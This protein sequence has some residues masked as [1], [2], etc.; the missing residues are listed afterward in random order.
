MANLPFYIVDVFAEARYAGNPLAVVRHAAGL[1]TEEMQA[2]AREMHY[3][4]TT[5]ILDDG[6][7]DG[8]YNVRIFTMDT[9]LAFAGHPTLGTAYVI[10]HEIAPTTAATE[11]LILNL[12]V[13]PIPVTFAGDG[14]LWMQQN[15]PEFDHIYDTAAIAEVLNL[16][17]DDLDPAHPVQIVSTGLPFTIVP[18]RTLNALKRVQVDWRR[19]SQMTVGGDEDL[20]GLL[21]FAPETYHP[22]NNLNVRVLFETDT[23]PEDPA[24][25]SANGCLAAYL[26]HRRYLGTADIACRVE[27]GYEIGRPSL[28]HL[29]A[30]AHGAK[31]S[32][33]VGGKVQMVARGELIR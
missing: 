3:S 30:K 32:V 27:Q 25:G 10:R 16:D 29:R 28:L 22:E 14:L 9:E 15:P 7:H 4:E 23:M 2:I 20:D 17:P 12:G 24:T 5:F 8:G 33:Q 31:I 26:V 13:G 6:L 19:F 18:I 11:P 21:L 1:S